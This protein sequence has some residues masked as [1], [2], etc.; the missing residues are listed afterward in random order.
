MLVKALYQAELPLQKHTAQRTR[1]A[2][3]RGSAI[4][5]VTGIAPATSRS[6]TPRSTTELHPENPPHRMRWISTSPVNRTRKARGWNPG[7]SQKA[8][9]ET[10]ADEV[11][12]LRGTHPL[13]NAAYSARLVP[14]RGFEPLSSTFAASCPIL[15][16]V[17]KQGRSRW[18]RTITYAGMGRD[19]A[20]HGLRDKGEATKHGLLILEIREVGAR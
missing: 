12:T 16:T 7:P 11:I 15:G 2:V 10:T 5:W 19:G 4:V 6:R 18:N 14:P 3:N 9:Q 17:A 8:T 20:L 13:G 1:R